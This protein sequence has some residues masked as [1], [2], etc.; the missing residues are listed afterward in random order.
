MTSVYIVV[1]N[2]GHYEGV[3]SYVCGAYPTRKEANKS[4]KDEIVKARL[5]KKHGTGFVYESDFEIKYVRLSM[6]LSCPE[7]IQDGK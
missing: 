2:I 4:I 5:G 7:S 3:D 1:L 6:P